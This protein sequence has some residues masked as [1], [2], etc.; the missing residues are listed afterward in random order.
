MPSCIAP[1]SFPFV[2]TINALF[3]CL[4]DLETGV[5]AEFGGVV[6]AFLRWWE[7]DEAQLYHVQ[8]FS[9]FAAN[10]AALIPIQKHLMQRD[11]FLDRL[12]Q[13]LHRLQPVFIFT[14]PLSLCCMN[15]QGMQ[16]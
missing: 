8:D 11:P 10:L 6:A 15:E 3:Y 12:L 13:L 16:S 4:D 5:I 14:L 1:R 7:C 2:V 9:T